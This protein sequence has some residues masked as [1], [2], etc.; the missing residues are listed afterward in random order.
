VVQPVRLRC[1]EARAAFTRA[2][3]LRDRLL[4]L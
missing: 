1:D 2:R 4:V 3:E